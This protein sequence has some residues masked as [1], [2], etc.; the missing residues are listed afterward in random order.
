MPLRF[1]RAA[2]ALNTFS[3]TRLEFMR[4]LLFALLIFHEQ[5]IEIRCGWSRCRRVEGGARRDGM[6]G[7]HKGEPPLKNFARNLDVRLMW[8][9]ASG[10]CDP[11]RKVPAGLLTM[12][13]APGALR[14]LLD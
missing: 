11:M 1:R 13:S 10:L 2:L 9:E 8:I 6:F 14:V 7:A 12:P 4:R 5:H 3:E